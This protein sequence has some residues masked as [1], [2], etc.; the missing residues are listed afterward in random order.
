MTPKSL[1]RH[2]RARSGIDEL[3]SGSFQPVLPAAGV[4][5]SP[6]GV[7]RLLLC[8]GKVYYDVLASASWESATAVDLARLE[9][10]YPFPTQEL[11]LLLAGY[12]ALEEIVW[13]QEEPANM[14]AWQAIAPRLRESAGDAISLR[15]ASRPAAA[16][17]AEGY[18]GAHAAAQE[19]IIEEA[20][21]EV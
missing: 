7:R 4:R 14:G 10:L 11:N 1:L 15:L 18:A 3:A 21:A 16:S 8:S 9:L 20:F 13:V 12:Q 17:P 19:R 6:D 5:P 2:P